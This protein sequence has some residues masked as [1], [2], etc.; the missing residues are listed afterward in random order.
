MEQLALGDKINSDHLKN[1]NM[2]KLFFS[3]FTILIVF[4]AK[5]QG[6]FNSIDM[7]LLE[8]A[9][10]TSYKKMTELLVSAE[11]NSSVTKK[12]NASGG[13]TFFMYYKDKLSLTINYSKD[14]LVVSSLIPS[15]RMSDIELELVEKEFK[16][17]KLKAYKNAQGNILK[18]YKWS[19]KDYPYRFITYDNYQGIELL[20]QISDEY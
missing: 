19:K 18:R 5:S 1:F 8:K 17:T 7:M 20:T 16:K 15:Q 9:P 3:I 14:T 6:N 4:S 2:K 13:D 12:F 11:A 10:V